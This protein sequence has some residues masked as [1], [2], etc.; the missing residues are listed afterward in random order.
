MLISSRPLPP[1][2]LTQLPS[3]PSLAPPSTR[4]SRSRSKSPSAATNPLKKK[5][6]QAFDPASGW[7]LDPLQMIV[8]WGGGVELGRRNGSGIVVVLLILH[9]K[10]HILSQFWPGLLTFAP[11]RATLIKKMLCHDLHL[12]VPEVRTK[13]FDKGSTIWLLNSEQG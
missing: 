6:A 2:R 11:P 3:L 9:I 4:A 7:Q 13:R 1:R 5:N 10:A 12:G 8:R